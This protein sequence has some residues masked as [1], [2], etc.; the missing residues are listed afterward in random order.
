MDIQE[1]IDNS[2]MDYREIIFIEVMMRQQRRWIAKKKEGQHLK[3][4]QE[5]VTTDC[6]SVATNKENITPN[7][8]QQN[9]WKDWTPKSLRVPA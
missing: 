6:G 3:S 1:I 5:F 9:T 2:A 4:Q 7:Q 8:E